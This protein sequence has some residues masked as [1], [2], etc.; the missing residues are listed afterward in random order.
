MSHSGSEKP[1]SHPLTI[2]KG[3]K[4]NQVVTANEVPPVGL[5]PDTPEDLHEIQGIQWTKMT[6]EQR[7]KLLL[8]Q[9]DL[10]GLDKWSDRN[11]AAA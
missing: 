8:Q 4:V 10:S 11:Q 6:V 3:I 7:K 9:L 5:T 2:V 1:D